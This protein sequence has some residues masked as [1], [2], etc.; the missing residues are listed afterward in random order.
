MI[1][2]LQ[3]LARLCRRQQKLM[4]PPPPPPTYPL[5]F[6]SLLL[7]LEDPGHGEG[8][9]GDRPLCPISGKLFPPSLSPTERENKFVFWHISKSAYLSILCTYINCILH[10]LYY[11]LCISKIDLSNLLTRSLYFLRLQKCAMKFSTQLLY[12]NNQ[13]HTV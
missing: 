11:P 1:G 8:G 4:L 10:F 3:W 13:Y 12:Y 7:P 6:L 2:W 9:D 5:P